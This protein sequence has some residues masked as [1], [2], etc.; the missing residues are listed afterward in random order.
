MLLYISQQVSSKVTDNTPFNNVGL[1]RQTI[2]KV[3]YESFSRVGRIVCK[4]AHMY[5]G[6]FEEIK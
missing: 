3:D 6:Y 1:F 2:S 5:G 4:I